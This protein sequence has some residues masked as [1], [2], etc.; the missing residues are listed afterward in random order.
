MERVLILTIR[1][2]EQTVPIAVTAPDGLG[3]L[4]VAVLLTETGRRAPSMKPLVTFMTGA[5]PVLRWG[6]AD[7]RQAL[8][9]GVASGELVRSSSSTRADPAIADVY[10]ASRTMHLAACRRAG[11][12]PRAATRPVTSR[13]PDTGA[14][15]RHPGPFGSVITCTAG[16]GWT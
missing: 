1:T 14:R 7:L 6:N 3:V 8:L 2:G 4:E 13:W 16:S 9:P 10:I 15:S 12:W 5:L 11:G